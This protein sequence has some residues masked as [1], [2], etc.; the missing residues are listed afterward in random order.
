MYDYRKLEEEAAKLQ[1][2]VLAIHE[3]KDEDGNIPADKRD[4]LMRLMGRIEALEETAGQMKDAEIAELRSIVERGTQVTSATETPEVLAMMQFRRWL[5]TGDPMD[6]SLS[7][8]DANGGYIVPE[9]AHAELI[10]KVRKNDPIFGRATLFRLTGDRQIY[11]PYK[12]SHGVVT[13]ATE[14][15]TRSEQDAPTFENAVLTCH[16]YYTDQ[17]ATQQVLDSVDGLEDM[18]L[19]W[20][21]EDIQ[22]QAGAD[23]VNGDGSDKIKGLFTETSKYTTKTSGAAGAL[24]NTAFLA[25]YFALPV[26]YR[27][28]AV[29]LM[30]PSTLAVAATFAMPN[31]DNTPLCQQTPAGE[32]TILGKPVVECDS[33]PSIGA[34][35]YPVAL[36]DVSAAYAV[37]IHRATSV[38]RDPYTAAPKVRFYGL[39]RLGGCAWSGEAAVL[40]KSNNT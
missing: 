37:G 34:A 26:K 40:L 2:Q 16:D 24:T 9:P 31:L 8:V 17:R 33:A 20:I 21:Y 7:T 1:G 27:R 12:A 6:A 5:L 35:N 14:T 19:G 39:A 30:S 18:L 13:T 11:L 25:V 29:W 15:G 4:E 32:W 10:E 3:S 36:A 23:A 22:E 28:N 38:L